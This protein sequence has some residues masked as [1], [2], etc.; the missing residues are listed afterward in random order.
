[1]LITAYKVLIQKK[2][3]I[4]VEDKTSCDGSLASTVT[5]RY[6]DVLMTKFLGTT[7]NLVQGD[8][9]VVKITASN[10]IGESL[11]STLNTI[12]ALV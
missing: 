5:N 2:D 8:E 11:E 1:M 9:I 4:F 7:F 6:C 10:S 12:K 3:G